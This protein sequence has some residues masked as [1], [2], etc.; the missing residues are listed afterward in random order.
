MPS[1]ALQFPDNGISYDYVGLPDKVQCDYAKLLKLYPTDDFY[2]LTWRIHLN[3][4]NRTGNV[5]FPQSQ[6]CLE[7]DITRITVINM[8]TSGTAI[9]TCQRRVHD[10]TTIFDFFNSENLDLHYITQNSI[11][12]FVTHLDSSS[13]DAWK[14][15][16]YMQSLQSL[17]ES[18]I[19]LGVIRI[20]SN[21]D[22]TYRFP[23][24]SEPKR[25]PD[26]IIINQLDSLFFD[27]NIDIPLD[28]RSIYVLLRLH[29]HR[30]SEIA[31]TPLDC[32]SY[33][34]DN[35]FAITIPN[36]KETPRHI[37]DYQKYNFLLSGFCGGFCHD[38]VY[39]Q[40][41]YAFDMQQNIPDEIK[42]Y[43]FI[44]H[45]GPHLVSISEFNS[46]L[47]E[48]CTQHQIVDA[49]GSPAKITSHD[50]RHIDVCERFKSNIVS[51]ERTSVECNHTCVEDTMG[52][53]YYSKHDEAK[54]LANIVTP[55]LP[56][57]LN[58]TPTPR[59]VPLRKY[60]MLAQQPTT[61]IIPCYGLCLNRKCSPQFEK[62]F[63]CNSFIPDP[64]YKEYIIAAIERLKKANELIVKKH[65]SDIV[66]QQN[67]KDIHTFNS[68]LEKI[69]SN[70]RYTN[71]GEVI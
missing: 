47:A 33:P 13:Y 64:Q 38:I 37:P 32:I 54:H 15:N 55:I 7:S 65:G 56:T 16:Q 45:K 63:H 14:R 46:F 20:D 53:G 68:Y 8:L 39:K 71:Q 40:Q 60:E 35:V 12:N 10:F 58:T 36:S 48:L 27:N 42:D 59:I 18:Y 4:A 50:L 70:N 1:T 11:D 34:A 26:V 6:S 51:P 31:A 3:M 41:Q 57:I 5:L 22:A 69:D 67:L 2:S 61:R 19:S 66:F 21:L 49:A 23:Q 17:I 9:T 25:A 30:F 62:C 52:Y 43:L 44:S 28:Y 24:Q 29:T